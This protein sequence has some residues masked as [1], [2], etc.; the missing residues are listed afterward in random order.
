MLTQSHSVFISPILTAI[1]P[2]DH[3]KD[4]HCFS[5]TSN[6]TPYDYDPLKHEM[7][8]QQAVNLQTWSAM[9]SALPAIPEKA[10]ALLL[11]TSK[12]GNR[13]NHI[14]LPSG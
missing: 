8:V 7:L 13:K 9:G 3:S 12:T 14:Y 6:T 10:T 1:R 5:Q 4:T 2:Q 11:K